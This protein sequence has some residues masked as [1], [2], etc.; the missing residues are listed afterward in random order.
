MR[1]LIGILTVAGLLAGYANAQGPGARIY[2]DLGGSTPGNQAESDAPHP[3]ATAKINPIGDSTDGPVR[4]YIYWEFGGANQNVFSPNYDIEVD[5]GHI[6]NAWNYNNTNIGGIG[7]TRW[8]PLGG[9]PPT[10]YGVE[11][12]NFPGGPDN[13]PTAVNGPSVSFTSAAIIAFGLAN[14]AAHQG[15][16][17]QLAIG[18]GEFGSTLLGYVDVVADAA[19]AT[20]WMTVGVQGIAIEGGGPNDRI[21]FGFLD[22][23]VSAGDSGRRTAIQEA[24]VIPEPASLMLLGLGVLVLRRRR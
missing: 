10:D 2:F 17:N 18:D 13:N 24:T 1:K 6:T 14:D 11:P 22:D 9:D 3:G 4:L 20:V 16:D 19:E 15:L 21:F 5:D 7:F 23:P 12:W 8:E